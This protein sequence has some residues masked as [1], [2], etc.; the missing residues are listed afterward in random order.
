MNKFSFCANRSL[1]ARI[2]ESRGRLYRVALAWCGD[3][4]LADDLVQ[5]ALANGIANSHQLRDDK[6]LFAWLYSILNNSWRGHLRA[7]KNHD[8]LDDELPS[9]EAG[10]RGNCQELE[11]VCRV[12]QAVAALPLDQRQVISLV[13]LE[14]F[15]YCEVA[16][17]LDIPIGTVMSRLH[18]ARKNLLAQLDPGMPAQGAGKKRIHIV[19]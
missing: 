15:S 18:R 2:A 14:E 10:P 7:R 3:P 5:E 6:R 19:K 16:E 13:D 9:E 1:K 4:M 17:A 11:I 12:R 8:Q